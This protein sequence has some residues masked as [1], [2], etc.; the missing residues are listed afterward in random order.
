MALHSTGAVF[1]G[2]AIPLCCPKSEQF[3]IKKKTK[4]KSDCQKVGEA[5]PV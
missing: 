2:E 1:P 4:K 5:F 3:K